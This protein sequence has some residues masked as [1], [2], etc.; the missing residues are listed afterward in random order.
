MDISGFSMRSNSRTGRQPEWVQN[1]AFAKMCSM[2]CL[3]P[4][5]LFE[6]I[7]KLRGWK[8]IAHFNI[9]H[10]A[11]NPLLL[12]IWKVIAP[13]CARIRSF[14]RVSFYWV[15]LLTFLKSSYKHSALLRFLFNQMTR[16]NGQCQSYVYVAGVLCSTLSKESAQN[17]VFR[18]GRAVKMRLVGTVA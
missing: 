11:L 15:Q 10:A 3:L 6:G 14:Y 1:Q 2:E 17:T 18:S 12:R 4:V 5:Y 7:P 13:I 9:L 8:Q 16:W